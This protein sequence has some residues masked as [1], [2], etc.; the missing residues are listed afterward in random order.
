MKQ[1]Y[2]SLAITLVTGCA[3]GAVMLMGPGG[4]PTAQASNAYHNLAAGSFVQDWSV[5]SQ[6][7]TDDNW[8]GVPSVLGYD[9]ADP[10]GTAGGDPCT[11]TT[12]P[13]GAQAVSPARQ[14][15][16]ILLT[17]AVAQF[18]PGPGSQ[19]TSAVVGIRG[20]T[21]FDAPFLLIHLNASGRQNINVKYDLVDIDESGSNAISKVALQWRAGNTG[22]FTTVTTPGG[23]IADATDGPSLKGKVTAVNVTLPAGANNAAQLQLRIM[24]YNAVGAP[25]YSGADEWIGIDNIN[26]SSA[27]LAGPTPTTGAPTNTPP[28]PT[29]TTGVPPT[30]NPNLNVK[31]YLPVVVK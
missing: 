13:F 6:F 22:P 29:A 27:A 23:C 19:V 14:H 4:A 25:S 12:N 5:T 16:S 3:I 17:E 11:A 2:L 31:Y 30:A 15:P 9:G 21:D 10:G 20:Q 18:L 1:R 28:G 8:N 24:T 7:T 26:I